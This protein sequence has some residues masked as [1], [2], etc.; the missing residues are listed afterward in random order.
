MNEPTPPPESTPPGPQYDGEWGFLPLLSPGECTRVLE[1]VEARREDWIPRSLGL[2]FYTLGAASYL[3]AGRGQSEYYDKAAAFNPLLE[4][5]FGWLYRRLQGSIAKHLRAAVAF[6]D[7]AARPGFHI[8]LA[9]P[10]FMHPIGRI[11]FDLQFRDLEWPDEKEFDF[12][13]SV[14]FTL[15]IRL[16]RSGAG[17][18]VWDLDKVTWDAMSPT[19]RKRFAEN[20]PPRRIPYRTGWMVCHSGM[21]MHRIAPATGY[22]QPDDMRITL[23]GHALPSQDGYR[24]Y[25]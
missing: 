20:V 10:A 9:H 21:L 18:E 7:R 25:W 2:P 19:E 14:S 16:P 24:L 17:L 11:H 3:D 6:E 4:R 1:R 15:A 12:S 5:D 13:R 22:P 8:F 23:Q